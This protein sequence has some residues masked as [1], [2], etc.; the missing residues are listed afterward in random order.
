MAQL[1]GTLHT[2]SETVLREDILDV[3]QDI[4]PDMNYLTTV[5]GTEPVSQRYHQWA[6]MYISR[7]TSNAKTVEGNDATFSDL[8]T[9]TMRGNWTQIIEKTFAVSETEIAVNKVSPKDAYAREMGYAMRR[10]KNSAEFAI[11]RGTMASGS[12]GVA[13]ETHGFINQVKDNGGAL[14]TAYAS[15]TSLSETLFNTIIQKSWNATDGYVVDLILT[16][17]TGK[18]D[19]SNFTAGNTQNIPA[20]DKRLVKAISV[21]ESDFG[22]HEIRAHKDMPSTTRSLLGLRKELCKVGYL[23][24]PGHKRLADTGDNSKGMINGELVAVARSSKSHVYA[25]GFNL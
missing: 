1:A 21:Y 14:Y 12:S 15:G 23:R 2:Y 25:D 5:L 11:V 16:T 7:D 8:T 20:D 3:I 4:S 24:K 18:Q 13:R 22:I 6:E 9:A 17:G 19:I 10:W